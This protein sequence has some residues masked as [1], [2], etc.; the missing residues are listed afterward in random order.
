MDLSDRGGKCR[1]V[2]TEDLSDAAESFPAFKQKKEEGPAFDPRFEAERFDPRFEA[3]RIYLPNT[4]ERF[5]PGFEAER[6]YLPNNRGSNRGPFLSNPEPL[7]FFSLFLALPRDAGDQAAG[8]Y[9]TPPNR[10]HTLRSTTS[11]KI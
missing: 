2:Q 6:I 11:V 9:S 5:D 10:P 8:T 4:N 7:V 3:E 1:G